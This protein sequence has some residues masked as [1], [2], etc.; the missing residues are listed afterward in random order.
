MVLTTEEGI[1]EK[2]KRFWN[3]IFLERFWLRNEVPIPDVT[4]FQVDDP[5][6]LT[7][8]A[9]TVTSHITFTE[10]KTAISQLKNNSSTGSTDIVPEWLKALNDFNILELVSLFNIWW[11]EE[12]Y[13]E[14]GQDSLITLLHKKGVFNRIENY[15]TLSL[16]C[17]LC[18]IYN[19]VICN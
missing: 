17:N 1:R 10:V 18:K 3:N 6:T 13:P 4:L 2:L 14:E 8:A 7:F 5:L 9:G 19:R 11:D 12:F 15:R 16:G